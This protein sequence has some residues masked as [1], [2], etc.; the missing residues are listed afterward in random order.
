M[1]CISKKGGFF[2]AHTNRKKPVKTD[3]PSCRIW[4]NFCG[5]FYQ[6]RM[7]LSD[8]YGSATPASTL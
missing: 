7:A 1:L 2:R 8:N 5:A 3:F 4:L 6:F